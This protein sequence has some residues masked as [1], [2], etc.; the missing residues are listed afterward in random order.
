MILETLDPDF[1]SDS[2]ELVFDPRLPEVE[3]E[4][5]RRL[6]LVAE[7][8]AG[9][10]LVPT[11]G[12]T[13][14]SKLVVLSKRAIQD[15]AAAVI[16]HLCAGTR[17]TWLLALPLFHVGGLGVLARSFLAASKLVRLP[18][19]DGRPTWSP[20]AF[21]DLCT[22]KKVT[23]TALVPTQVFDLVQAG[24]KAPATLRAIVV[25]GGALDAALY[26]RARVLGW[27]LLPSYGMTETASQVATAS[28]RSLD[29]SP[30]AGLPWLEEL[31]H[32]KLSIGPLSTIEVRASSLLD[33]YVTEDA[34]GLRFFDPK[35][36][37]GLFRSGDFGEIQV[38]DG[39]TALRVIGRGDDVVKINAESVDI[40][41]LDA[42]LQECAGRLGIPGTVAVGFRADARRGA[43][44]V[45]ME[46]DDVS[47][48]RLALL[49]AF[50]ARVRPFERLSVLGPGS[51]QRTELGKVR[52]K[53]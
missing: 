5:L 11:S 44:L 9:S 49:D 46:S 17:D 18:S 21:V 45:L 47:N 20:S 25:G 1:L 28:L 19:V 32:A 43:E 27:R 53:V 35:G 41:A 37:D 4:R 33:G 31:P 23:L 16:E 52:R 12:T 38:V 24:L 8:R 6:A 39:K 7:G 48:V 2:V 30:D 13:G 22:Q 34:T 51:L 29:D 42:W 15:S 26:Q 14:A 50:H 40:A 10:V 36:P 3:K